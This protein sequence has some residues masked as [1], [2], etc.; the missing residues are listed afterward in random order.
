MARYDT[1]E[2]T[3]AK[4]VLYHNLRLQSIA[5]LKEQ[6]RDRVPLGW[7]M[8]QNSL[9]NALLALGRRWRPS[10]RASASSQLMYSLFMRGHLTGLPSS[11]RVCSPIGFSRSHR[12]TC[13]AVP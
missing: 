8:T 11:Y 6:T 3:L 13:A 1:G 12:C 7:A 10:M 4:G 2:N 9:G 5:P